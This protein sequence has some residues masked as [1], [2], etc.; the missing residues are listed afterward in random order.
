MNLTPHESQVVELL[1]QRK[2]VPYAELAQQLK[3]S[4]KTVQRALRRRARMPA[5]TAIPPM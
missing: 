5:S 2:V 1:R 3:V 4:P